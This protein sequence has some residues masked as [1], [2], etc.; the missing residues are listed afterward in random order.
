MRLVEH[1]TGVVVRDATAE[2]YADYTHRVYLAE[3]SRRPI[4]DALL[5]VDG[6]KCWVEPTSP[7]WRGAP[8]VPD[9]H[10]DGPVAGEWDGDG[11]GFPCGWWSE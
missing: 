5:D 4:S 11:W 3:C 1:M 9:T 7:M 2:E 6:R 8:S 10:P